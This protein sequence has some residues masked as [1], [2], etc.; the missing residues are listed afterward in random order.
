MLRIENTDS[1]STLHRLR[2]LWFYISSLRRKQL[3]ALLVIMV[4]ASFAEALSIGAVVPFL[5]A[6]TAPDQVFE[7][8]LLQPLIQLLGITDSSKLLLP[9][10]VLFGLATTLAGG[11][12]LLLIW[13]STRI[14]FLTGADMGF[15]IYRR[16][17]Y[18]PYSVHI[19]RNSSEVINGISNKSNF[20]TQ[21]IMMP[22]L[23]LISSIFMLT[24]I[25]LVIVYINPLIAISTF[26]GFGVIYFGII[27]FTRSRLLKNSECVA[28][29]STLVIKSIQEGL[30][31][32]R[33]VLIDGSQEFYC[34]VYRNADYPMRLAQSSS[35][36]IGTS[37]RVVMESLGMLLI[38]MMA[39][40]F[41]M[42]PGGVGLVIPTLGALAL[43]AQRLLPI[44]QQAYAAWSII[45]S[46]QSSLVD[47]L[48]FLDQELPEYAGDGR[49]D[50]LPFNK[51]VKFK[52]MGF[53]Y[54]EEMPFVFRNIEFSIKKGSTVGF[55][56]ATGAGKS[57]L[58]D[59]V[60]GLLQPSEGSIEVDGLSVT[61]KRIRGWQSN[62]AHVPQFVF[63]ADSTIEENIA[64]GVPRQ[65][66]DLNRVKQ[67]AEEAQISDVIERMPDGYNT[68]VGER[69]VRLSGGQRQRLGI[70]RALYK[71]A[72]VIVLD[73]ATSA[74][75]NETEES[76]M[77]AIGRLGGNTTLLIIAHRLSTLKKCD[78]ILK[79]DG[80][81]K[82]QKITYHELVGK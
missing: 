38:A 15:S 43:G 50:A 21:N 63:L 49:P 76:V 16:T 80:T 68:F 19:N 34:L 55:A 54:A 61:S 62:I 18:Q 3:A 7:F 22:V 17:L 56:G 1:P 57:T 66:I 65:K 45:Q 72:G 35:Q 74:L 70:A 26:F 25:L 39:Y 5:G 2:R 24:I 73:E 23:T 12:R 67:V 46:G 60:M 79:I 69:G 14:S 52:N 27:Y 11:T 47:T 8:E 59:V 29:E 78:H 44:M 75:D 20:V 71:N 42:Q 30:G 33:D 81:G 32:I 48:E 51:E 41:A 77:D 28:K 58:L 31:G 53:R 10:T 6:L 37:P 4:L 9:L 82:L 13:A 64:F 40:V 36:F